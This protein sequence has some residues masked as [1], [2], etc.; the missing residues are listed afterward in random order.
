MALG[1]L[2]MRTLAKHLMGILKAARSSASPSKAG[3]SEAGLMARRPIRLTANNF[4]AAVGNQL[5]STSQANFRYRLVIHLGFVGHLKIQCSVQLGLE[6]ERKPVHRLV[7]ESVV[8][9]VCASSKL[10]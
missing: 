2:W 6:S 9:F 8:R 5:V 10:A 1:N 3:Q 4:V 7:L